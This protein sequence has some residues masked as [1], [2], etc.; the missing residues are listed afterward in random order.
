[1][2]DAAPYRTA[3]PI[4]PEMTVRQVF[5]VATPLDER[6]V[7]RKSSTRGVVTSRSRREPSA[8]LIPELQAVQLGGV[9]GEVAGICSGLELVETVGP[10]T[11]PAAHGADGD[12]DRSHRP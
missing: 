12:V 3:R 5:A 6:T 10:L 8:G 1:L 9:G 7:W 11:D 4:T 2:T